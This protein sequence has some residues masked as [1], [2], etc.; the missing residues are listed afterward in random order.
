MS[1]SDFYELWSTEELL[2]A[3]SSGQIKGWVPN[4]QAIE[5]SLRTGYTS[6]LED[7]APS[8][9]R[10]Y[11]K[12]D[13]LLTDHLLYVLPEYERGSQGIGSCV[14]WGIELAVTILTAK[15]YHKAF[16]RDDFAEASTEANYGGARCEARGK[17]FA[18][19]EDGAFGFAAADFVK[20]FGVLYRRDY[21]VITGNPEHDLRVYDATKEKNWGAYG[22]GGQHDKGKL[23]EIA[24]QYPVK[25][26][27]QVNSFED[28]AA[29]I[30]GARCPVTIASDY[31]T[32]M[33]RDSHG[34][35]RWNDRWMHQMVL[36]GVRFGSHPGCLV[37]Q[38]WGPKSSSGPHYPSAMP[39]NIQGFTWWV[40]AEDVDRIA[41]QGDSWGIGDVAG[42]ELDT[43][44]YNLW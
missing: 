24:R 19:W 4:P 3:Y 41:R 27:S 36:V 6:T 38:S 29:V 5:E 21:S 12:K 17:T 44:N 32:D 22:C 39:A 34:F 15:L 42:W 11:E 26:V 40:P 31:G 14:G 35:C 1:D 33:R 9:I 20:N 7:A 10:E 30:A 16:M 8:L 37:A 28:V 13:T 25:M 18:G 43:T 23:D 2:A